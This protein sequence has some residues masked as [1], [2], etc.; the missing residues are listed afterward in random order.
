MSGYTLDK[1]QNWLFHHIN[2]APSRIMSIAEKLV[3]YMYSVGHGVSNERICDRF[4]HSGQTVS[5]CFHEVSDAFIILH[6]KM[7]QLPIS[8]YSTSAKIL[9]SPKFTPYFNDCLGVFDGIHVDIHV[10]AGDSMPWRNRKGVFTQNVLAVCGFDMLFHY[11]LPGWEGSAYDVRVFQ[12]AVYNQGFTI[13]EGKYYLADAGYFNCDFLLT[14]YVGVRYH[15]KE[16][17]GAGKKPENAKE[18]FNLRHSQLRNVIERIFGVFKRR[19]LS[20]NYSGGFDIPTQIRTQLGL[21][22]FHNFITLHR[23]ADD[24]DIFIVGASNNNSA[25]DQESSK[26][27]IFIGTKMNKFRDEIAA[28]MWRDYQIYLA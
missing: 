10:P 7:V 25:G 26:N 2:L 21:T 8:P 13:P 14:P 12:D 17:I 20:M 28:T 6:Q 19:F 11:V 15:L 23:L 22:V 1:L 27:T 3:M 24:E 16:Q 5:R 9:S 4:Q 18:L